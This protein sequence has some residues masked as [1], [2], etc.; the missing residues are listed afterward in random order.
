MRTEH[1]LMTLCTMLTLPL[2]SCSRVVAH[3]NT[4]PAEGVPVRMVRAVVEDVPLEIAAVGNVEAIESVE[5]KP[6]I[7]GQIQSVAFV[8]GQQVTKGQ[9]LFTVD[10]D[11]LHRQQAQQQAE[12][13]RDVAMGDQA[14]AVAARDSALEKQR[15]AEAETARKEQLLARGH[16]PRPTKPDRIGRNDPC[17]CGGG[18]KFKHCCMR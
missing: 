16:T 9:L 7:G 18:K 4:T 11:T 12:L 14:K 8:E 3:A 2:A 1:A 6:R 13:D 10:R 5:V 15:R 17:P